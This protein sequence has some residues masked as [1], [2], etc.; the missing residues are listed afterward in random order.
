MPDASSSVSHACCS[1]A[2]DSDLI[3]TATEQAHV[4]DKWTCPMHPQVVSDS[5]GSCPICGMS[6]EAVFPSAQSADDTEYDDLIYRLKISVIFTVPILLLAMSDVLPF[7][8]LFHLHEF[9]SVSWIQ[10]LLSAPVIIWSGR[11]IFVRALSS[12][13]SLQ[14][15]MFSLLGLGIGAA[16]LFS[17]WSLVYSSAFPAEFKT[18]GQIPVYFESAAVI[19]TLVLVGQ[20]LEANAR[21]RT[22]SALRDLLSMKPHSAIRVLSD[23][24]EREIPLEEVVKGDLLRVKP[25][26]RVPVDGVITLGNS[27]IDE[28]VMTGESMPVSKFEGHRV[29]AGTINQTGS[30]VMRADKVG[31]ETLLSQIIQMVTEAGRS[32]API[33]K[34]VDKATAYF[35][36]T[37]IAIS[38]IAFVIWIVL[39]PPPSILSA[40]VAAISVLII[41]CPCALGLATPMSIMVGVGRGAQSGVLIKNAEALELMHQVDTLVIDKTGTLT[42]GRPQ[43]KQVIVC[44]GFTHDEVVSHALVLE[45]LSEHPLAKA[46]LSYA[47]QFNVIAPTVTEFSAVAGKG[48]RGVIKN[49]VALIGSDVFMQEAGIEIANLSEQATRLRELGHTVM[50]VSLGHRLAGIISVID[51]IK[52]TTT[53]AIDALRQLGLRIVLLTGDNSATAGMVA[54]QLGIQEVEAEVLPEDKYK[55]VQ[56][57]QAQGHKVA[58]AGDGVN[59]APAIA[60]SDVG[61]AMGTGTDVAMSSAQVVLVKG[62]LN[63]IVRARL[64]SQATMRNI[65]QNLFFAFVYNFIGV[66]IAAG[67]LYP[68]FGLLLSPMLA[69]VA[70][71]MSSTS[72]IANSLRLKKL[73]L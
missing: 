43:V 41:A 37:V 28:S 15:N 57:L 29:L 31:H 36:P 19:V 21:I 65:R 51:P 11:F 55:Y 38:V 26:G 71:S 73:K 32:R 12:F 59:D 48:V 49:Q 10:V 7:L 60:I 6:L 3:S 4:H 33:Q 63:G 40:T 1:A 47:Q 66:F 46:I 45:A 13:K 67:A 58:M 68:S 56:S 27:S 14:L 42:E 2:H 5:A 61:I 64:L 23:G 35:V 22:N 24:Q 50:F 9:A 8:N 18:H 44:N 69:S 16:F 34:V 30:F 70:M 62:D 39:A 54:K 17:I 20:V 53:A 72:V 25:G 52:S